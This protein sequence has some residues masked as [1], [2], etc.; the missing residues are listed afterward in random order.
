MNFL[1]V[2]DLATVSRINEDN[3]HLHLANLQKL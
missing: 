2:N 1:D 3:S